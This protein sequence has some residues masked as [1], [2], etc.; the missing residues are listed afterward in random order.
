[1]RRKLLLG[2]AFALI[3]QVAAAFAQEPAVGASTFAVETES[4]V[5][6]KKKEIV[7]IVVP[8]RFF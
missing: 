2:L 7:A 4:S 8:Q 3:A 6:G 1:M 5:D